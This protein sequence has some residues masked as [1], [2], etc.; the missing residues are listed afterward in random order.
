MWISRYVCLFMV[1]SFMGWVYE[2]VFCTVKGGKWE[3]RGFLIGPICPIYGTGAVIISLL[4]DRTIGNGADIRLWQIYL[5]SVVGSALLE[6]ITS[7]TLEKLFH[8]VWWDYSN[9]PLNIH[10]RISLFTSLGF[11]LGGLL[12]VY[13]IAPFTVSV[14]GRIPPVLTEL[15]ALCFIFLFAADITL[16]VTALHHFDRMVLDME[17]SFNHR[18]ESIVDSAVQKS[19][20]LRENMLSN[21]HAIS[22]RL[23]S[24][25]VFASGTVRRIHSFRDR[26]EHRATVKN[27]LLMKIQKTAVHHMERPNSR[28][29]D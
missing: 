28:D 4:M 5:I 9:L 1:Y 26:N 2:T 24:L 15:L 6:Y 3:N 21:G 13:V 17:E 18:M 22:E 23:N 20:R 16:T 19:S 12:I 8:A 25:S 27:S 10:G 7:W 11:G 29:A 14:V